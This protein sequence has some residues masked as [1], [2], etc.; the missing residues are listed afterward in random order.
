MTTPRLTV[1]TGRRR[2]GKTKSYIHFFIFFYL[3]DYNTYTFINLFFCKVVYPFSSHSFR[4]CKFI[5]F[6]SVWR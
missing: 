3:M 4:D 5:N 6:L 1:V 2:I